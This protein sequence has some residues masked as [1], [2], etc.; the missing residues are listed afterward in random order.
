LNSRDFLFQQSKKK[1]I[2]PTQQKRKKRRTNSIK[3]HKSIREEKRTKR[4]FDT[5]NDAC[6]FV[7]LSFA[8]RSARPIA[9][10]IWRY[11]MSFDQSNDTGKRDALLLISRALKQS[12]DVD[13]K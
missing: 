3:Q 4:R 5:Q 9:C 2:S 8:W 11:K 7:I 10:F 13:K 1:K 12:D 6:G